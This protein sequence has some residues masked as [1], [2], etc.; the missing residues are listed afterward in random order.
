MLW[1][2]F[3]CSLWIIARFVMYVV[4]FV[5]TILCIPVVCG[6]C[7]T[8]SFVGFFV[9][10]IIFKLFLT[11]TFSFQQSYPM[12]IIHWTC[13]LQLLNKADIYTC[14]SMFTFFPLC[15]MQVSNIWN[16]G[17]D[18]SSAPESSKI[19]LVPFLFL[20]CDWVQLFLIRVL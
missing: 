2:F 9:S 18:G 12:Y 17:L 14:F 1:Y 8:F 19:W 13:S 5:N 16:S 4:L 3:R 15:S 7:F 20:Y 6:V 10:A 11:F